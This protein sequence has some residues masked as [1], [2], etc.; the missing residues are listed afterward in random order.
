MMFT[1]P[2]FR[3]LFV[4]LAMSMAMVIGRRGCRRFSSL[5]RLRRTRPRGAAA[6]AKAG[7]QPAAAEDRSDTAVEDQAKKPAGDG[8]C[9]RWI[10]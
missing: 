8:E 7:G 10:R 5:P 6:A 2:G 4:W 1:D 9:R 3:R